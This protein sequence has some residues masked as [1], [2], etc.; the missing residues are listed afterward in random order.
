MLP[1]TIQK[2]DEKDAEISIENGGQMYRKWSP[3]GGKDDPRPRQVADK[4]PTWSQGPPQTPKR[5]E[6]GAKME[7][8]GRQ[9]GA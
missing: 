3:K 9:K 1:K 6:K 7:P 5:R 2:V 8:K 4:I